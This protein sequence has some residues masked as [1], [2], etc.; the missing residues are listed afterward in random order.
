MCVLYSLDPISQDLVNGEKG[1]YLSAEA[2]SEVVRVVIE[3]V[4]ARFDEIARELV[5]SVSAH[6]PARA[7]V[8]IIVLVVCFFSCFCFSFLFLFPSFLLFFSLF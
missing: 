5:T 1:A 6:S 2:R 8:V 7:T 3:K 4:T